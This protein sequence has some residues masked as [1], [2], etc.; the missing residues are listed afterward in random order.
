MI[1]KP[2]TAE[3]IAQLRNSPYV[4][5]VISGRII[6]TPEFK[7]VM[8]DALLSDKTIREV[9]EEHGIDPDILGD[10]RI[11][12]ITHTLRAQGARENGFV[13][14]RMRNSRKPTEQTKEQTLAT[15]V[16]QLE[17]KL[18][19]TQ[20]EVEFLKKIHAADLEARKSW[21]SRQRQK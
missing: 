3:E 1:R 8:Y 9:L 20:Q 18:A 21:E 2:L 15:R 10:T 4:A 16:E 5:S 13:D 19:Y 17:H 14:L 12:S 11:Y 6:F 7:E